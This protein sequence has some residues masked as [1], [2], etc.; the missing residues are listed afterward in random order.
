LNFIKEIISR[1]KAFLRLLFVDAWPFWAAVAIPIILIWLS[2]HFP[3]KAELNIRI[4]GYGIALCGIGLVVKGILDTQKLFKRP[5]MLDRFQR[6]AKQFPAIFRRHRTIDASITLQ[7]LASVSA[8]GNATITVGSDASLESRIAALETN[9]RGMQ[10]R[11]ANTESRFS[12]ELNEIQST[13]DR[14]RKAL[15]EAD[16]A[17]HERLETY[18]AGGLDF[19]SIGVAW[20]IIGE[21]LTTFPDEIARILF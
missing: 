1:I 9:F 12:K 6:W 10:D 15:E 7:G 5:S 8:V 16:R 4:A 11:I 18:S 14:T 17:L 19:E 2:T 13:A 21:A 3:S 20:F